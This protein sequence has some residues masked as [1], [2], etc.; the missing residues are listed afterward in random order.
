MGTTQRIV[1]GV[2]GEPNWGNLS[3][4]ITAVAGTVEKETSEAAKED[5][6]VKRQGQ[7]SKRREEQVKQTVGRLILA[8]GGRTAVK[9]GRSSTVGRAGRRGARRLANFLSAVDSSGLAAALSTTISPLANLSGLSVEEA[10][11]RV[12]LYCSDGSTGMDETA[13]NAACNHLMQ[14]FAEQAATPEEFEAA[15]QGTIAEY[16]VEYLLCDYFGYYIFEHLS[17]RFQEKITQV[18]GQAISV[19]TFDE[20][21]L[22]IIG[23]VHLIGAERPI[24]QTNWQ[25]SQGQQIIDDI[26]DSVLAIFQP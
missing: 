14:H 15:M 6:N 21:K 19:A 12:I 26:F 2:T 23:R 24:S 7:L 25:S 11:Q 13:A 3:R 1:P 5:P 20:I 10:I 4:G 18:R 22:D 17:Q 8:A 16:G 9:Q